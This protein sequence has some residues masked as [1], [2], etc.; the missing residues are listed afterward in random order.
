MN[1][2]K[3][4]MKYLSVLLILSSVGV[5]LSF[6]RIGCI[7]AIS[8]SFFHSW[9]C[10]RTIFRNHLDFSCLLQSST[11]EKGCLNHVRWQSFSSI[12]IGWFSNFINHNPVLQAKGFGTKRVD[13]GYLNYFNGYL[14]KTAERCVDVVATAHLV[15]K[16]SIERSVRV[17]A[18]HFDIRCSWISMRSLSKDLPLLIC[19]WKIICTS[20]A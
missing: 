15:Q 4:Y 3:P 13:G 17:W 14:I 1:Q 8:F 11:T 19:H 2:P 5:M 10:N 12:L 7:V 18:K 9:I 20:W 16:N 6:L